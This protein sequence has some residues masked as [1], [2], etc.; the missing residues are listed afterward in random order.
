MLQPEVLFPADEMTADDRRGVVPSDDGPR[1][2]GGECL[3]CQRRFFPLR[4]Q[5]PYCAAQELKS[6]ILPSE[7][8][9]YSYAKVFVSASRPVPYTLGYVDLDGDVRVLA[10]I[11]SSDALRPDMTV[12]LKVSEAGEWGFAP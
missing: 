4:P 12:R 1:L 5:C 8:I 11:D 6:V 2:R 7:G 9:L 10:N 3:R